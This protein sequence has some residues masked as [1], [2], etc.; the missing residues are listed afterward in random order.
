MFLLTE[1]QFKMLIFDC[2]T[3]KYKDDLHV[4][5]LHLPIKCV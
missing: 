4:E 3:A 5:V 2:I 1:A